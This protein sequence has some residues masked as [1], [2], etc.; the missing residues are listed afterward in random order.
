[1]AKDLFA[2]GLWSSSTDVILLDVMLPEARRLRA[3]RRIAPLGER[4][5]GINAD[6]QRAGAGSRHGVG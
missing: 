3:V 2:A 1:M 4:D 5:S 6:R